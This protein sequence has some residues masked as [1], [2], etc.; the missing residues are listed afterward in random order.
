MSFS[1]ISPTERFDVDLA[2]NVAAY[3]ISLKV[4]ALQKLDVETRGPTVILRGTVNSFFEKQL[5]L[6]CPQRIPGIKQLIDEIE[7]KGGTSHVPAPPPPRGLEGDTI[8]LR[9]YGLR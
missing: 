2:E 3:L 8:E 7:V 1:S 4:A 9:S 6:L 5:A